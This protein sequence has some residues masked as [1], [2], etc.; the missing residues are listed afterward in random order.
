MLST[1]SFSFSYDACLKR[2][3]RKRINVAGPGGKS[4]P[5]LACENE[6]VSLFLALADAGSPITVGNGLPLINSLIHN[7]DHQRKYVAWRK[8]HCLD[9]DKEGNQLSDAELGVVGCT[10][11][12]A[13][14]KRNKDK[15]VSNK[16]RQFEQ[17]R[18]NWTLYRNFRDMYI[19]V[20]RVMVDAGVAERLDI[21][22]LIAVWSLMKLVVIQ[23]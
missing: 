10:Y 14:M 19:D 8:L 17:S 6:F 20:E 12:Y 7:T 5:L 21:P 18:M 23:V 11:W 3:Q 13:F 4:S 15:L 16:G 1:D 9:K 2:M 22:G